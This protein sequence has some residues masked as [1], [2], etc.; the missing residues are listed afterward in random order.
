MD[1]EQFR[2]ILR[3]FGL[4]WSGY[5]RVR[6]GVMKRL[7]THMLALECRN[8]W[9]YLQRL[10]TDTAE[11]HKGER[12]MDVSVSRFFRDRGLWRALEGEVL[13]ELI[14]GAE[15]EIRVWSAGC[16]SG[17]EAYSLKIVWQTLRSRFDRLPEL[18][19]WATDANPVFLERAR[20]GIYTPGSLKELPDPLRNTCFESLPLKNRFSLSA[21]LKE[22]I[23]WRRHNLVSEDPPSTGFH[24]IFLR[25]NLLTYYEKRLQVPAFGRVLSALS[26]GG[27]LIVGKKERI[28]PECGPLVP[29]AT[30][31]FAFEKAK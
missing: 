30:C 20:E 5:R 29:H 6:R 10:E 1:D 22:G 16:A 12:F 7:R 31:P 8:L 23:V 4:S 27:V 9:E 11:R 25:N 17:E 24:L 21:S 3:L 15:Q 26:P 2:E 13:P 28:P 14:L 19:L 18:E